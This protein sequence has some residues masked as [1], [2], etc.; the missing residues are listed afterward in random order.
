MSTG[1]DFN[2]GLD[3]YQLEQQLI[4]DV[5]FLK[6]LTPSYWV[7]SLQMTE[8]DDSTLLFKV[9]GANMQLQFDDWML[10]VFG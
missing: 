8:V 1:S 4:D 6:K 3:L 5:P 10:K 9:D 2:K 7:E